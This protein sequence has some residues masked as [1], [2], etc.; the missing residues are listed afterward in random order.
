[1]GQKESAR[2]YLWRSYRAL[3]LSCRVR[4]S[5]K[6]VPLQDYPASSFHPL[7]KLGTK[8][9]LDGGRTYAGYAWRFRAPDWLLV[10]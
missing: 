2:P 5:A 7:G 4:C 1:M 3:D 10:A 6:L 9:A 8:T